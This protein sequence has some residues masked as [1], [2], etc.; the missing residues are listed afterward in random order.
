MTNRDSQTAF[1]RDVGV[2]LY[3]AVT[4]WGAVSAVWPDNALVYML[5]WA[6]VSCTIT[7]WCVVDSRIL[8]CPI[9]HSFHWLIFFTYPIAVPI[10]LVWSRRLRG[11]GIAVLHAVGLTVCSAAAFNAAGYA[12]YGAQWFR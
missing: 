7:T 6:V 9:L 4:A 10:Y 5:F 3:L 2:S 11:L 8:G 12:L 1:R